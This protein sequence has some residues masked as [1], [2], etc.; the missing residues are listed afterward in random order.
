[1]LI[2]LLRLQIEKQQQNNGFQFSYYLF[3]YDTHGGMVICC[4]MIFGNG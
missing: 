1:M 3:H 4:K 2:D